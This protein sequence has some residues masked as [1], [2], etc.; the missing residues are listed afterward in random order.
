M[1]R[2]LEILYETVWLAVRTTHA[3]RLSRFST[4]AASRRAFAAEAG[5]KEAQHCDG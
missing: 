2:Q 1:I 5:S 4:V 3:A